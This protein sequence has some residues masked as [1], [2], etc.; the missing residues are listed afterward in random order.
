MMKRTR[1]DKKCRKGEDSAKMMEQGDELNLMNDAKMQLEH[2][3]TTRKCQ[4]F[5]VQ[6][7]CV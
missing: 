2:F 3:K 5:A 6:L 1:R 7:K 4:Q